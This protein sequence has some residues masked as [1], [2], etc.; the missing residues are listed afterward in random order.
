MIF[1]SP[2]VFVFW[3]SR[4]AAVGGCGSYPPFRS[5]LP[6]GYRFPG[7]VIQHNFNLLIIIR[8]QLNHQLPT[9]ATGGARFA[10]WHDCKNLFHLMF[11]TCDHMKNRVA[12]CTNPQRGT[13]IDTNSRVYGPRPCAHGCRNA[14]RLYILRYFPIM[15]DHLCSLV[16]FFPCLVHIAFPLPI[17]ATMSQARTLRLAAASHLANAFGFPVHRPCLLSSIISNTAKKSTRPVTTPPPTPCFFTG[18]IQ[19]MLRVRVGSGL[20]RSA[21]TTFRLLRSSVFRL[22]ERSRTFPTPSVLLLRRSTEITH[23]KQQNST[24]F[25]YACPAIPPR[26]DGFP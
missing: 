12:L 16:H 23:T 26:K 4:A 19:A 13:G 7:F 3:Q 9:S 6:K 10:V 11:P 8:H 5:K 24:F 25:C 14:A 20:D 17:S 15:L 22:A 21:C 18:S 1:T 2:P